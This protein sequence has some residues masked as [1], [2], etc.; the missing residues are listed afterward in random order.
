MKSLDAIPETRDPAGLPQTAAHSGRGLNGTA[1]RWLQAMERHPRVVLVVF[2]I[3][4]FA[5]T[6]FRAN[7]KL[8][9]F[10]ELFTVYLAR[11]PDF[12]SVWRAVVSGVDFNPPLFYLITRFSEHIL[13]EGHIAARLPAILGF[14]IFCIC[15][16]RFISSRLSVVSACVGMLFPL[17]TGAY[18]YAYEA[19]AHGVVLGFCGLALVSWQAAA[20]RAARRAWW[21]LALGG[22]LACA[23]LTHSYAFLIFAPIVLG[24]LSRTMS[25][26]RLDWPLWMTIAA[27]S[28]AVLASIPFVHRVT[29]DVGSYFP[30]NLPDL[31]ILYASLLRPAAGVLAGWLVLTCLV[32]AK[33][34]SPGHE[35]GLRGYELFALWA[36]LAIP[37]FTYLAARLTGGPF[38]AR[39]AISAVAGFAGLL[40]VAV[41]KRPAAGIGTLLLLAGQIGF[42]FLGFAAGSVLTEP[43]S[44]YEISTRIREFS[45]RYEWLAEDR[46]LPILLIDDLD[47]M[48]TSYYAPAGVAPQLVYVVWP[49]W[50]LMGKGYARLQSC[51]KSEPA[52]FGLADFLAS[53]GAFLVYGGPRSADR[54]KY[55]A[56]DGAT[57]KMRRETRDHFLALVTY[58][59]RMA[60]ASPR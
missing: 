45:Q 44:G 8:F 34:E 40:G 42:A 59:Q 49:K 23:L 56:G 52:V 14:W 25:R 17:V 20:D 4:Y 29:S 54:L 60:K 41:A 18:F 26:K 31:I 12:K 2:S 33:T 30:A 13:G 1:N 37:V 3:V 47:F 9:W 55:F 16:F 48:T 6:C 35:P 27:S 51:C 36:F 22:S 57:V 43:S 15:L 28:L 39:Y 46:T 10:D 24:E 11:L 53:H 7:R 58:P 38:L 32:R 50:D 5:L 19:R 21:L